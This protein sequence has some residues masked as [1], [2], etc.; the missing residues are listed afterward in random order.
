MSSGPLE[1]F[2]V[3]AHEH[4]KEA[5]ELNLFMYLFR[6]GYCL[7]DHNRRRIEVGSMFIVQLHPRLPRG[8]KVTK[9]SELPAYVDCIIAWLG[10]RHSTL[11]TEGAA[12]HTHTVADVFEQF[13]TQ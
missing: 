10:K 1:Q 2:N 13:D 3:T 5:L 9:V 12:L 7:E 8:V 11:K 4:N 6:A